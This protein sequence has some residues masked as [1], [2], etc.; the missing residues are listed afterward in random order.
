MS[1]RSSSLSDD[2]RHRRLT[3]PR[4]KVPK[5]HHPLPKDAGVSSP[6]DNMM[7]PIT[8]AI[9]KRRDMFKSYVACLRKLVWRVAHNLLR[10]FVQTWQ[11]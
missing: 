1:D 7:S 8:A 4:I 11:I 5:A 6:T 2:G 3:P 9:S 10:L